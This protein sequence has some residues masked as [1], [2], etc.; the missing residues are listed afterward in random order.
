MRIL[1]F[2]CPTGM[3]GD[4]CIASLIDLGVSVEK[5]KREL[6]KLRLKDYSIGISREKRHAITGVRFKV[7]TTETHHHRTFKDIKDLIEKSRLSSGVKDSSL[8]MFENL[9]RAEGKVH[10]ISPFRVEFHEVGAVDSIVDIVGVAIA[11]KALGVQAVYS[12]ALPLGSGWVNTMHGKL[13]VPPPATLEIV[14]GMPVVPSPIAME[15]TTPTGAV[16][17]KTLVRG[18]GQMPQMTVERTGYGCGGKDFGELPNVVRAVLGTREEKD[19]EKAPPGSERLI[20]MEANIDDMSPQ[21]AGYIMEKLLE[22]GALDVFFTPVV[23][24]KSRP[25]ILLTVLAIEAKKEELTD[26]IFRES[27]SIGIRFHPVERTCLE[28]K[29]LKVRTPYGTVRVKK[30]LLNGRTVNVQPE[31][32]DCRLCAVKKNAPVKDVISAARAMA[33]K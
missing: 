24:K 33:G 31:Y 12:S 28:R 10:C 23:M 22:R 8:A 2:D 15:L 14:K 9:A 32:E 5:I 27:T 26:I 1:Y 17:L 13:P 25:G 3:S 18:F 6:K 21:I 4:M 19:E 29:L 7:R 20:V 30:S 11:I 16:I